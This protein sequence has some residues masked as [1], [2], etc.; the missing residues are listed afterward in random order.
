MYKLDLKDKKLLYALEYNARASELELAKK[1]MLSREVVRYRLN[2]LEREGIIRQYNTVVDT[3]RLGFLMFRT[4]YKLTGLSVEKEKELI[5]FLKE[6]VNWVTKVE[7]KW[8]LTTMN[9]AKSIYD[10]EAFIKLLK[11][12]FGEYIQ[13]YWVSTMTKLHHYKRSYLIDKKQ[14]DFDL[15]MGLKENE[16]IKDIDELDIKIINTIVTDARMNSV[17]IAKKVGASAKLVRERIKRM[18]KEKIILG[19]TTFLDIN[20]LGKHYFKVH[21]K[22][23]NYS[24]ETYRSLLQFALQHPNIAYSVEAIGGDDLELELQ[25]DDNHQLYEIINNI[26]QNFPDMIQD[27]YFMEYTKEFKYDYLPKDMVMN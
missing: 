19:F 2:K 1:T 23:R 26:K 12:N 5:D 4:Y 8:N 9:F 17:D 21:F 6:H 25:V 27:Y 7:G 20:K 3:L 16:T 10:Y 18:L 15:L 13:D 22:L 14:D 11:Q 24:H